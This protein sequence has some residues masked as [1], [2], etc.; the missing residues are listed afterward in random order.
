MGFPN[1]DIFLAKAFL[2]GFHA[3]QLDPTPAIA[4]IFE[5]LDTDERG[6]IEQ[7]LASLTVTGDVR[8]HKEHNRFLY[9][10]PNFP[11]L[12]YPFPQIGI[13]LG[14]ESASDK[15]MGDYTGDPVAVADSHGTVIG[16]DQE[17]G[18]LAAGSWN[19]DIVCA[20]KPEAAWLS[21]FCQYFICQSL[22]ALSQIGVMEVA[23][24]LADMKLEAQQ[25][26]QPSEIFNRRLMVTAK[27]ANTWKIRLPLAGTYETGINEA[28]V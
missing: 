14:Q 7:Y 17:K 23:I 9:V 2:D 5:D 10:M 12:G 15:F 22:T 19:I 20:T 1:V 4:D 28:A 27:V 13:S 16:Y 18:Y 8:D 3:Q 21:R 24:A 25:T 26:M 6:S 11:L